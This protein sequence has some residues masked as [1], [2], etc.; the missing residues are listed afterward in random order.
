ME[1]AT[2]PGTLESLKPLRDYAEAAAKSVGLDSSTT[3]KLCLAV[4]EVAT[5]IIEHGYNEAGRTG[6]L[7][8]SAEVYGN[9]LRVILE[10]D[11][12]TYD[13]TEHVPP[14]EEVLASPLEE[15]KI[16]GLGIY[17]ARKGVDELEYHCNGTVNQTV[18]NVYIPASSS[19]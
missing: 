11:G 12:V 7:R 14:S 8:I 9:N 18:F 2:F 5:N 1:Q 17:L 19:T 10:D 6:T 3:Y 13:P 4:D 15:R 16:G